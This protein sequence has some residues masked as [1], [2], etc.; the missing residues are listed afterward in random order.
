[1]FAIFIL[2][3]LAIVLMVNGDMIKLVVDGQIFC[4]K[5]NEEFRNE[6]LEKFKNIEREYDITRMA[7]MRKKVLDHLQKI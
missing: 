2:L 1:M 4:D 7:D 3:L 5:L 6:C